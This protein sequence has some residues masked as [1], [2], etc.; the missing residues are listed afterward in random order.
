MNC[1]CCVNVLIWTFECLANGRPCCEPRVTLLNKRIIICIPMFL[2]IFPSQ[3]WEATFD[4]LCFPHYSHIQSCNY[5][6]ASIVYF[7]IM[8][9]KG[10]VDIIVNLRQKGESGQSLQN[11]FGSWHHI[12][13]L[14]YLALSLGLMQNNS[15]FPKYLVAVGLL[16][17]FREF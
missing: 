7:I 8:L 12:C 16:L 9:V 11:I 4:G 6:V 15:L 2:L 5:L 17:K 1:Q 14:H 3:K 13:Y 10:V